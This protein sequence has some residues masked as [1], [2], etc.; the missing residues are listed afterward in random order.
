MA[1]NKTLRIRMDSQLYE[2]IEKHCD[3]HGMSASYL[4]RNALTFFVSDDHKE[5]MEAYLRAKGDVG[6][7]GQF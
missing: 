2:S 1:K 7:N 3:N 4:T 6:T 5:I